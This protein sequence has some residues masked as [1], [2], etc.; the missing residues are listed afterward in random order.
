M[1]NQDNICDPGWGSQDRLKKADSIW[2]TML[3]FGGPGIANSQ[4]LDIGC[5]SGGIAAALAPRVKYMV[6]IDPEPWRRWNSFQEL[7]KN[8]EFIQESSEKLTVTSKSVD[9]VICNQVY[10]HVDDPR[11]LIEEIHRILKP[12]GFCYFAGPNLVYPIEPH[13]FWP[14]IHWL[15]RGFARK[16]M[17]LF[18]AKRLVDANSVAYWQLM[19]WFSKFDVINAVPYISKYPEKYGRKGIVFRLVSYI[20]YSLLDILTPLSPGFV[21]VLSRR[22]Q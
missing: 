18:R 19:A 7:N 15:P 9:V 12:G 2:E 1:D 20:P 16:L 4:W 3:H 6:G 22:E 5:G 17:R 14:F 21:F 11:N 13:V 10:E 8:L